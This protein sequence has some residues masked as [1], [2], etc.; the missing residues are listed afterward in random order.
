[1]YVTWQSPEPKKLGWMSNILKL[2]MLVGLLA[3]YVG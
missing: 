2:D 1:M 3:I